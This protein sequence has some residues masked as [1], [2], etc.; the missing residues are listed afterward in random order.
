MPTTI[1]GFQ[2]RPAPTIATMALLDTS[3]PLLQSVTQFP[4]HEVWLL[5]ALSAVLL[6]ACAVLESRHA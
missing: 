4:L 6:V 3:G 1:C 5:S 2:L